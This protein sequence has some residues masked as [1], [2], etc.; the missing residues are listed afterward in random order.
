MKKTFYSIF[1]F[2]YVV[3]VYGQKIH[4]TLYQD[5]AE[6]AINWQNTRLD[7]LSYDPKG[8][9]IN[10]IEN[11][12]S[13]ARNSWYRK[14][15]HNYIINTDGSVKKDIT[16]VW[17]SINNVWQNSVQTVNAYVAPNR[18]DTALTQE[19]VNGAWQNKTIKIYRC[20]NKGFLVKQIEYKWNSKS[21]WEQ[22]VMFEFT[23][24]TT[25]SLQEWVD[26][27][28][29]SVKQ[30]WKKQ[31]KNTLLYNELNR[32]VGNDSK[33]WMNGEW[34]NNILGHNTYDSDGHLVKDLGRVWDPNAKAYVNSIQR[35]FTNNSNG[36]VDHYV[37]ERWRKDDGKLTNKQM[38][39]YTYY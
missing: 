11:L 31:G 15:Q 39:S 14:V 30:D 33:V 2:L 38:V 36:T 21:A 1:C 24:S 17:D 13:P 16:Q 20:D 18:L 23:N 32:Y 25:G 34:Q 19:W 26:F 22:T 28:W 37:I 27:Q 6:G 3:G 9:L 12:W 5:W 10:K 35:T 4:T 29:D 7:T 8:I